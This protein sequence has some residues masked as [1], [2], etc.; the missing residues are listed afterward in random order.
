MSAARMMRIMGLF[1]PQHVRPCQR[2]TWRS[3]RPPIGRAV[4]LEKP[5]IDIWTSLC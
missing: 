3:V 2:R 4:L 1:L 5:R